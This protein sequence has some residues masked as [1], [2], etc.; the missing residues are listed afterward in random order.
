VS[1]R[2]VFLTTEGFPRTVFRSQVADLLRVLDRELGLRF[3]VLAFTPR[4]PE[5][6]LT[7]AGRAR[8]ARLRRAL[9]GRL[10]VLPYVPYEDRLGQPVARA[11]LRRAL[12][13][14]GQVVLHCRG[15]WAAAMAA[16][17]GR[18]RTA[19]LYDVRGDYL[20]EHVHH[21]TGSG[22][23]SSPASQRGRWR[24]RR[25]EAK[26]LRAARRV[27]C[28]SE[29][30]RER[31]ARRYP[32]TR[33]RVAVVPCGFDPAKFKLHER[34]R[35]EW[36]SRLR[37][38][39]RRV[40]VYAG[41]L[42]PYHLPGAIARAAAATLVAHPAPRH[43]PPLQPGGWPRRGRLHLLR[44]RPRRRPRPPQRR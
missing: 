25:A 3:D 42:G 18:P 10:D 2:H 36:R 31:L 38:E 17:L 15:L 34:L 11:L 39:D 22:G 44:S 12:P 6:A 19:F 37:L 13:D 9:P 33:E 24:I 5:D 40:L 29:R 14:T 35:E 41:A 1:A 43:R 8:V 28:V 7:S 21:H 27:L 4:Y 30:L 32:V 26:A 23:E 20:A 16:D